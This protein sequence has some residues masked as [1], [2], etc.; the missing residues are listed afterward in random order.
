MTDLKTEN[1]SKMKSAAPTAPNPTVSQKDIDNAERVQSMASI[2]WN[3]FLDHKM[4]L[5]GCIVIHIL[6]LIALS[7]PLISKVVG[8]N[9]DDQ[10][11]INR[12]LRPGEYSTLPSSQ[13]EDAFIQFSLENPELAVKIHS[14]LA[15]KGILEPAVPDEELLPF[16]QKEPN[17]ALEALKQ[18]PAELGAPLVPIV[19]AFTRKHILGTDELGRDVFIRLVYGSR[20]SLGVGVLVAFSAAL[21]GLLIGAIAGFYGGI[22]DSFLMRVTD[23]LLS[24]PLLPVLIVMSA[25]SLDKTPLLRALIPPSNE[26]ILKLVFVLVVFS[27]MQTALLVRSSILSLREREFVLAA[28]TMGAKNFSII[29][30]HLFPNVVAPL[31]V[32]VTIGVGSSI[33]LEATLSFLGLGIQQPTPSWGNMLF[34][35]QDLIS[36]APHLAIIPGVLILLTTISFNYFGDGLRDAIDPKSVKR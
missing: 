3:Q 26:N 19:Q 29:T 9:P 8:H 33:Q 20:V 34:N 27:W 18:I 6:I 15:E 13:R 35:A 32:S 14:A 7:A 2:V 1:E 22:V 23:S 24:L 4:A 21:I 11:A 17:E 30:K 16:A 5:T 25:I 10:N 36:E 31:L 12:Y 28:K